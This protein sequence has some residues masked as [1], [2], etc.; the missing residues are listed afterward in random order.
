MLQAKFWLNLILERWAQGLVLA[1]AKEFRG[2]CSSGAETPTGMRQL[3]VRRERFELSSIVAAV[4]RERDRAFT[5]P[6]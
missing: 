1:I 2:L 5:W 6:D 4:N 3:G